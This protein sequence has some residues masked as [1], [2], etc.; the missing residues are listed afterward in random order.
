MS[1]INHYKTTIYKKDHRRGTGGRLF[2]SAHR[3]R[4][5]GSGGYRCS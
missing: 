4:G 2:F 3:L 5:Q 1:P